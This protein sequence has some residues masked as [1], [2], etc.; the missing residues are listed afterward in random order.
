[1]LLKLNISILIGLSA[2]CLM[3]CTDDEK[4]YRG[5]S[6]IPNMHEQESLRAQEPKVGIAGKRSGRG[7]RTPVEGT[8]PSHFSKY[9]LTKGS[10]EAEKTVNPLNSSME[11]LKGGRRAFN[12]YCMVCHGENGDGDG[13]IIPNDDGSGLLY[14]GYKPKSSKHFTKPPA[15]HSVRV[16]EMSDG[17]IFNYITHGGSLMPK[18][19]HLPTEMR[20]SIVHYLRVLFKANH[21]SKNEH[22]AYLKN[23]E[24]LKDPS[25]KDIIHNWR[26]K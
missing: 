9:K 11:I 20:W 7:M 23:K 17:E 19:N 5:W 21:A 4:S 10:M 1:M 16:Y 22:E 25:A 14:S 6:F 2:F 13:N 15:L 18:Y 8:V 24:N 12:I 26:N 3:G